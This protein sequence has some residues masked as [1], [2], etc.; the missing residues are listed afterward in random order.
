MIVTWAVSLLK[1]ALILCMIPTSVSGQALEF[2]H[3][4][5]GPGL[6]VSNSVAA[7]ADG[8]YAVL[9]Y[10]GGPTGSQVDAWLLRLDE[11]GDTLWTRRYGGPRDDYAWDLAVT[12]QGTFVIAGFR[13]TADGDDDVWIVHD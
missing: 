1:R 6:H 9:G 2:I 11:R 4:F 5:G 13:E 12:P 10:T 7:M 3:S 8:G